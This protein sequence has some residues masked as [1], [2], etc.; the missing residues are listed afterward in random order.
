M[1]SWAVNLA[2]HTKTQEQHI[3]FELTTVLTSWLGCMLYLPRS[4]DMCVS[5]HNQCRLTL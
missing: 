2:E 4:C 1:H 5:L 3:F